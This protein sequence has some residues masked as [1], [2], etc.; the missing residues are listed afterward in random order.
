MDAQMSYPALQKQVELIKK[1]KRDKVVPFHSKLFLPMLNFAKKN[2][3]FNLEYGS[4][5]MTKLSFSL[6]TNILFQ[7]LY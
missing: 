5:F 3:I 7:I 6:A 1:L 2:G 4:I